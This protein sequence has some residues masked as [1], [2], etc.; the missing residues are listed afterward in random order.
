[1]IPN[2]ISASCWPFV[3]T[4]GT[5]RSGSMEFLT[6]RTLTFSLFLDPIV[7]RSPVM[8]VHLDAH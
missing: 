8:V 6:R 3:Y 5:R 7:S 1:M 4:F 2:W